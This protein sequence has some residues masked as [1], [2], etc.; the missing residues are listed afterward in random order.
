MYDQDQIL[1]A[2]S[3]GGILTNSAMKRR[4]ADVTMR[5]GTPELDNTHGQSRSSGMTSG[6]VAAG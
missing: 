5:V 1:I 2:A 4:S 3:Y 6:I